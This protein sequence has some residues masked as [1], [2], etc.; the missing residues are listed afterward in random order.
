MER[1]ADISQT[2]FFNAFLGLLLPTWLNSMMTSSNRNIFR[3]TGPLCGEFTGPVNSPHKGH[4]RGALMF[5]LI[6]VWRNGRVNNREAGDLRRHRGHYDVNVMLIPASWI[7]DSIRHKEWDE[8]V[9]HF[10]TSTVQPLTFG[11]AL[12]ILSHTLLM[13]WLLI[14]AGT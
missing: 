6:C 14:N 2:P 10:Q 5:S 12:L 4:W 8:I 3:V 11:N 7:S 1:N 13:M 9:I